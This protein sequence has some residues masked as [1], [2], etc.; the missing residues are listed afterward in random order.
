M[1]S[2]TEFD[3]IILTDFY[4]GQPELHNRALGAYHIAHILRERGLKV[5]VIDF[6]FSFTQA[7]IDKIVSR[8]ISPKTLFVGI[9]TTFINNST[10]TLDRNSEQIQ[11]DPL[12]YFIRKSKQIQPNIKIIKGGSY[13]YYKDQH[14]DFYVTGQYIENDFFALLNKEF[15]LNLPQDYDFLKHQF[16]F[17]ELDC[18]TPK[19]PLP[20]EVSR[21]CIFN[22]KFCGFYGRGKKKNESIKDYNLIKDFLLHAHQNYGTEYFYLADDTFNESIEKLEKFAALVEELPFQPKFAC[23]ARLELFMQFPEMI[24]LA[25]RIGIK[26]ITFGIETLNKKAAVTIGK[27]TQIEKIKDF[28]LEF[29]GSNPDIHT[30]SGFIAGLPHEDLESC[31]QTND[32]LLKTKSLNSWKFSPLYLDN[33]QTNEYASYFSK[34]IEQYGY[35]RDGMNG[36]TRPD[37]TFID[38]AKFTHKVNQSN[39]SQMNVSSW[40]LFSAYYRGDLEPYRKLNALEFDKTLNA[41]KFKNYKTLFF[42]KLAIQD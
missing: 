20:L 18:I 37:M 31:Q 10:L 8:V 12:L 16:T 32:W 42:N 13:S 4:A 9:S 27:S 3:A 29:K 17:H 11:E 6:L 23:Y 15:Q 30:S 28:L 39:K 19:E 7:E 5:L 26:G 33:L 36:W 24:K 1:R 41:D 21:G 35:T 22:C 40:H 34:N 25:R 14:V 2:K 38:A